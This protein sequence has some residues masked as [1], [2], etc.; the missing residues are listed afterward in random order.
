M[1]SQAQRLFSLYRAVV[2]AGVTA[3]LLMSAAL[4]M[5][6]QNPV[7][8]TAT[9]AARM[10]QF[11]SRLAHSDSQ[12]A[13]RLHPALTRQGPRSVPPQGGILYDNGPVNGTTDAWSINYGF[14][15]S[16]TFLVGSATTVT[17]MNFYAWTFPGDVLQTAQV[18]ITSSEFGGTTYSNQIV[19]FS[20]SACSSN[21]VG[22]N[23]CLESSNS[24]SPV[25]LAAGTYWV[26]LQNAV[27]NDG[28]PLYWDENSG[29]SS[30]SDNSVGTIPSESFSVLGNGGSPICFEPQ[31]TLHVL[32]NFTEQQGGTTGPAGITIDRAGN[33]YGTSSSGGND[34]AG[35][36]YK[37][38]RFA[39]WLLDP[40]FSFFGGNSG[41]EPTGAIVGPN[42]SLY[43]G[44][45][46]G[47]QNCGSDGSQYCGLVYN[48][49][50]KPTIC[51]IALCSWTE[52][53]P[54][55]FSSETDGSGVIVASG[56]D[57]Q[58]NLYG[59]TSAGGTH[60][61]GTVFELTRSGG[62][63]TKTT[64]YSFSGA[65]DGTT[66]TQLLVGNDGNLYGVASGGIH[67]DGVVFQLTP[68]GG[69]WTQSVVYAFGGMDGDNSPGYLVQDSAGNLYG[70]AAYSLNLPVHGAIF[71]L[72]K[73]GSSWVFSQ[74]IVIHNEID[75]LNN[76]AIDAAGN[77][78]GTGED[79]STING[80]GVY[81]GPGIY[82]SYDSYI[83]KASYSSNGWQYEDV[84][85]LTN[86]VFPSAGA[87]A[88][89]SGG[90]LYGTTSG[91]GTNSSG[92]AW[93]LSP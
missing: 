51:P 60:D 78:Y 53:V 14:V 59:V 72:V 29:P 52:N 88:F 61:A 67:G 68:S 45:Q 65:N 64:L 9:Q 80:G 92:T 25:N 86:E 90:N 39:N 28:D 4:P 13:S 47:I 87:L 82:D 56:F 5:G 74:T 34:S 18:T 69:Q 10:P 19:S 41:G 46:G 37:L 91:C 84:E 38:A 15:V 20:Q 76:L 43:G 55:R 22:F 11:A 35:F 63:W 2:L 85:Y 89:D 75:V 49:T 58:G 62:V 30:A 24:F 40:L 70:I 21:Q 31:G 73:T 79:F 83:F 16:D 32:F 17:G 54:Y 44:A 12:P 81:K 48:L 26:N 7:P 8:P 57:Q 93:Q 42:G 33:L 23:V 27:V 3:S 66:P 71:T 77:L 1:Q 6:A 36:A 50:P